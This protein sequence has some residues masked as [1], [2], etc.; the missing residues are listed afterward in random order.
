MTGSENIGIGLR[1][2]VFNTSGS[3]NTAIGN[4]VLENN[5]SGSQNVAVGNLSLLHNRDGHSN[6]A[7]GVAA[8]ANNRGSPEGVP[9]AGNNNTAVGVGAGFTPAISALQYWSGSSN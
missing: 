8:L 6:I 9:P 4:D 2:F 1:T 7:I 3:S 5:H